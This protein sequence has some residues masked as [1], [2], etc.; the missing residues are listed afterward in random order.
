MDTE[1]PNK[2]LLAIRKR[3][4]DDF[5]FWAKHCC[6]IRTKEGTIVPLVL[7]RVQKRFLD[8][9]LA[10]LATRGRVRMV[11]LKARQQGL[12][13]V[14]SALQYWWIS[15][16]KGFKG[17]VMAHEAKSTDVLFTMYKRIHENAPELVR[18]KTK[19]INSRELVFGLLD[20]GF[21][22]DTAGGRGVARGDTIQFVHLSEVAFW[23]SAFAQANFNGLIQAVPETDG[24]FAF[25]ESTAQGVTGKFADLWNDA[26]AMGYEQFFSGWN[27]SDEYREE[28]PEGFERTPDEDDLVRLFG[29]DDAQLYWRRRKVVAN[30]FDLFRQEYPLT[31]EEAFVS[32]GRPVFN[33][34]YILQ[35]L[36]EPKAPIAQMAV[37]GSLLKEHPRG[38]LLVYVDY[39]EKDVDGKLTG[40]RVLVDPEQTYVLGADVGMGVGRLK[41]SA[42]QSDPS[43]VQIL[44]S[45][46]RQVAVWRGIIHPDAF[47][48]ILQAI[49]YFYNTAL[50]A[51]ERNNHGLLTCVRL[52]DIGYP[53]IYTDTTE[54]T[55]QD[56]DTI[57]IGF[58]TDERT[59]PL[60]IDKLRGADRE[61]DI[62][63]ND[64]LTLKEM[65]TFVVTESGRMEAEKPAHDD[66]V[67]ALA[68]AN[69]IHEGRWVPVEFSDDFYSEAI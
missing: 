63:I 54:G 45:N 36:K 35:R 65:Y 60:I 41:D 2:R 34:D 18:P 31:P 62:E 27:E 26:I 47:A 22:V 25:V 4:R 30:G 52:R 17:L 12:S 8:R 1:Q 48:H 19:Y 66:T 46:K 3:L 14:I 29:L 51:P 64:T 55:L 38:E 49:G 37:E 16:R 61:R 40:K 39:P 53:N 69:H 42:K 7:N 50:I 20:S 23:P 57:R 33:P 9:V 43:V 15:Q 24:T 21:R 13:T 6:Q 59:K 28:A 58:Y 68:I 44:D 5:E 10:Q 32:T 67:M 11:V 56:K